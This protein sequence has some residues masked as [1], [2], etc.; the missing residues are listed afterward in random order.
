MTIASPAVGGQ[1]VAVA[2]ALPQPP[3]FSGTTMQGRR[4]FMRQYETYLAAINA[5]QTQ[6]GGTFAMPI[7]ACVASTPSAWWG[8][9]SNASAIRAD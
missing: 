3:R 6:W 5:L 7:G 1:N 2:T 4:I 9:T 8:G